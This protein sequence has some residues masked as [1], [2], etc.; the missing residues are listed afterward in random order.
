MAATRILEVISQVKPWYNP[1]CPPAPIE[2][3]L[4]IP[5]TKVNGIKIPL[6]TI[7]CVQS[8]KKRTHIWVASDP[9][10]GTDVKSH[11]T[12]AFSVAHI[13]H[14]YPDYFAE[15]ERGVIVARSRIVKLSKQI[16]YLTNPS[17]GPPS[18]LWKC[19]VSRR[20][21]NT[22]RHEY[23]HLV[24]HKP[25][26]ANSR[27]AILSE[28]SRNK[29]MEMMPDLVYVHHVDRHALFITSSEDTSDVHR[30]RV[31]LG[32]LLRQYPH[33][34]VRISRTKLVNRVM[35]DYFQDE[36]VF[37]KDNRGA[38]TELQVV[39]QNWDHLIRL[40]PNLHIKKPPRKAYLPEL[41]TGQ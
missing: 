38:V 27:R 10:T 29:I 18:D 26:S 5:Y 39:Y 31:S 34:L 24:E 30:I 19:N 16:L 4:E 15:V 3:F 41:L 21:W 6:D 14:K 35:V 28:V 36:Q 37:L 12:E 1:L 22:L 33:N 20:S 17:F 25:P 2:R 7:W 8:I 9:L 11:S 32:G 23:A 40:F 13:L